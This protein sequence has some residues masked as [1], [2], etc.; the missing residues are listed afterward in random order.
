MF[1]CENAVDEKTKANP[2]KREQAH[3][4]ESFVHF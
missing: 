1:E 2:A 4:F 3:D